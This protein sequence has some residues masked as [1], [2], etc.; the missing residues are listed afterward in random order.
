MRY[1][2]GDLFIY[3]HKKY[4]CIPTNGYIKTN[5]CLV[6]GKGVAG[7][8]SLYYPELPKILGKHVTENGNVPYI[9]HKSLTIS[10]PT[11]HSWADKES[12][13][14]L[15][16]K[17]MFKVIDLVDNNNINEVYLPKIG[18]GLGRLSWKDTINPLLKKYLDDR[19]YLITM[20]EQ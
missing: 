2:T 7:T 12:D 11:K 8:A 19:F 13:L 5:G 14:S 17:S 3:A 1:I 6:M 9:C 20:E 18:C 4:V 10:W 15:I 16:E